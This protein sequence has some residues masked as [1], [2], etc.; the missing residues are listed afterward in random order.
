MVDIDQVI[1]EAGVSER[2]VNHLAVGQ[3]V[4]VRVD[5]LGGAE[6]PASWTRWR[7]WPISRPAISPCASASK[8]LDHRLKPGMI[9]RVEIPLDDAPVGPA[10]PQAAVVQRGGRSSVYVL[11]STAGLGAGFVVRERAVTPGTPTAG[12]VAVAGVSVGD[13]VVLS[14]DTLRDGAIVHPIELDGGPFAPG[15]RRG[16][17]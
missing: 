9:A 11:E 14:P 2:D 1:I 15:R 8:T 6:V 5:A 13:L 12:L 7:R 17:M 3:P 4:R 16:G 10:V